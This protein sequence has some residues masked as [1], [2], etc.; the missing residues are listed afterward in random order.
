M[1][2][3]A[4][5]ETG[6]IIRKEDVERAVA[7]VEEIEDIIN[8]INYGGTRGNLENVL[9]YLRINKQLPQI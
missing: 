6:K 1:R 4:D 8:R 9:S 5:Y 3:D 2:K 7:Y